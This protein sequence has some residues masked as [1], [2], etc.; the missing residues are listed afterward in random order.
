MFFFKKCAKYISSFIAIE[1][2]E[3]TVTKGAIV[4]TGKLSMPK[5]SFKELIEK[6]GYSYSDNITKETTYLI[7]DDVNGNSS[8]LKKAREKGIKIITEN[9]FFNLP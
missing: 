6:A 9:E 4:I 8:K 5:D 7:A 2:K 1:E 3:S